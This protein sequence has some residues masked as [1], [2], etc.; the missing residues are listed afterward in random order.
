MTSDKVTRRTYTKDIVT[1]ARY[2][3]EMARSYGKNGPAQMCISDI[4]MWGRNE[5]TD[6]PRGRHVQTDSGHE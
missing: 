6:G 2:Q 1:V 5:A 4:K 3:V